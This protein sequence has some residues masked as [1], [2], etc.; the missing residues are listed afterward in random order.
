MKKL[1]CILLLPLFACGG[2]EQSAGTATE[3]PD[4]FVERINRELAAVR[5]D[6]GTSEWVFSTYITHDTEILLSLAEQRLSAWHSNAVAESLKFAGQDMSP[7][8]A[9]ALHLL[10]LSTAAPAPND[11]AKRKELAEITTE[12]AGMYGA[13]KYCPDDGRPCMALG[14]LEVIL[15]KSRDYDENLDAWIG[16]RTI[17]PP[18]RDKYRRFAQL[19]NEGANELGFADLGEMWR[20]E[21][22]MSPAEFEQEALRLYNQVKPLYDELHCYARSSLARYYGEDKVPLDAPI[23]AHLLGNMWSQ[24]WDNIYDLLEPYPG[25]GDVD[26][27][28]T[29]A[30]ENY[31]PQQMVKSAENFY[32]SLGFEPLPDTFWKRSQFSKPADRDVICHASAWGLDGGNDLRIK[33]CIKQ[34]YEELR[35]I[36]HELGHNFYQRAY[37]HQPALFQ[38]SAHG[39][40]HEAIGDT[41]TLSMTP[42]YL[43]EVGLVESAEDSHEA[44]VNRQMQRALEGIA[45]LPW[46]KLVDEWRWGVFSGAIAPGDYNKAWWELRTRYQGVAAPVERTEAD[47]DPGAKYHVPGNTSYTRYF[48]ARI[49]Q[50]QFQRALCDAAGFDGPLHACS[51]YGSKEA[52]AKLADMLEAGSSQ[53][54][55]DT[56]EKL[57]GTRQMDGSAIIEYFTPLMG[58]LEQQNEGKTCGW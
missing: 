14:E 52:G 50:F 5:M 29:L 12:L 34:S 54:W 23:P 58:W 8:T 30:E 13:G 42:A 9:R 37:S 25:V 35:V 24:T 40:F 2:P 11:A 48:L 51:V 17:S 7:A 46:A 28:R 57:T 55:Q 26:V 3:T 33:M 39:G 47:F 36:Y 43:K 21:Y 6:Q 10:K 22:D 15:A 38:D 45:L 32:L 4:R 44:I 20:A 1:F 56:L 53:P 27:D 49:L 16:W 18:M 41:V 31:T 19:A